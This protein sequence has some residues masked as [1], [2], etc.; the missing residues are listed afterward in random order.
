MSKKKVTIRCE[1]EIPFWEEWLDADTLDKATLVEKL[2]IL[3]FAEDVKKLPVKMR[4]R[5]FAQWLNGYF[6]DLEW[7]VYTK[8][9]LE[10]K[11]K[12]K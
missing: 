10:K 7:A 8:M 4:A 2:P 11:R 5:C 6:E 1:Y 3:R 9:R 12:K